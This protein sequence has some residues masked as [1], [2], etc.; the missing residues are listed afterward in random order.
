MELGQGV[1][2]VFEGSGRKFVLVASDMHNWDAD[3]WWRENYSARFVA[4]EYLK[5]ACYMATK[6]V[7]P[8]IGPT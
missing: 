7:E 8:K 1:R 5:L 2:G 6:N 4:N 3:A